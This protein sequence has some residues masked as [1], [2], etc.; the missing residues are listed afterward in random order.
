MRQSLCIQGNEEIGATSSL[1]NMQ[2]V[3][4]KDVKSQPQLSG[5]LGW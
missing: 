1:M 4:I 2:D 5:L 3:L